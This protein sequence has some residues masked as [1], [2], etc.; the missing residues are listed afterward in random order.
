MNP[1]AAFIRKNASDD[2]VS[3]SYHSAPAEHEQ[4]LWR[5]RT[6]H[7]NEL[8]CAVPEIEFYAVSLCNLTLYT[9][10]EICMQCLT[11]LI[12]SLVVL[13]LI[14]RNRLSALVYYYFRQ[15]FESDYLAVY[16]LPRCRIQNL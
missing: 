16:F 11:D 3:A 13:D 9:T 4:F 1:S 8:H 2:I 7:S 12:V 10:S 6:L 5:L 14:F 15:S